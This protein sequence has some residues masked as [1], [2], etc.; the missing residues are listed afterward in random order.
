MTGVDD[1]RQRIAINELGKS[2]NSRIA[3]AI[4]AAMPCA[5]LLIDRG[6]IVR[7]TNEAGSVLFESADHADVCGRRFET[8]WQ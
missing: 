8:L 2:G 4:L 7:Y 5:A 1:S 6:G 3:H